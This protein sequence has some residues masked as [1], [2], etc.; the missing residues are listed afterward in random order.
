M[1]LRAAATYDWADGVGLDFEILPHVVIGAF[2][3][4]LSLARR[5]GLNKGPDFAWDR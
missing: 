1:S 3:F 5:S 2:P 4:S